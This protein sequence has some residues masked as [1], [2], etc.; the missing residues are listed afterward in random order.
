MASIKF[1]ELVLGEQLATGG[2]ATVYRGRW[3]SRD[4][5]VAIKTSCPGGI[6]TGEVWFKLRLLYICGVFGYGPSRAS[7]D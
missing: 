2:S 3:E 4:M 5:T 6:T 1:D 7:P